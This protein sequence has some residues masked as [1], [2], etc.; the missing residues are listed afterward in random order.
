MEMFGGITI[1][2]SQDGGDNG[3]LL[4]RC[5]MTQRWIEDTDPNREETF[6]CAAEIG[7]GGPS[8]EM[9][10]SVIK[11]AFSDRISD[12]TNQGFLRD[13]ALLALVIL[14][15]ED[16]CSYEESVTLGIGESLCDDQMEPVV[17]YV[18]FL[19]NLTGGPGRWAVAVIAGATDCES[20]FGGAEEAVR[21]KEFVALAG[22]N[23][24][25]SSICEADLSVALEDALNTFDTA[26]DNFPPID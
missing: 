10:L 18:D 15:D 11:M 22:D 3:A 14:T 21:L 4:Q 2:E 16:D 12:G 23:A 19:N 24:V 5:D 9:P 6:D 1:P 20:E 17:S 8:K 13:N 25:L 7:D 26:C